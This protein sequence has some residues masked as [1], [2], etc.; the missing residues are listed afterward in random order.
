MKEY[1]KEQQ[2]QIIIQKL[3]EIYSYEEI[4]AILDKAEKI[5]LGELVVNIKTYMEEMKKLIEDLSVESE[6]V[7]SS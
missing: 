5:D 4:F 1:S 6:E 2:R 3:S 7:Y